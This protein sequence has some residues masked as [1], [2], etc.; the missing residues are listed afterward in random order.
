[1]IASIPHPGLHLAAGVFHGSQA[2]DDDPA[3]HHWR[4][5]IGQTYG[6]FV[7]L[8]IPDFL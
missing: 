8:T 5:E 4:M 3:H 7:G 6:P 2:L 1:M